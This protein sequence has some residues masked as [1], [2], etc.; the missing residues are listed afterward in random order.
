MPT[1]QSII[2]TARSIYNDSDSVL[3]RKEDPELL[4]YL[5]DGI[6]EISVLKPELF[7]TIGDMETTPGA[8]EHSVTFGDAQAL[9]EVLCIHDGAA[10][11]EFDMRVMD[12]FNPGWRTDTAAAAKQ[13]AR[14][15]GDLLRFF[16]WPPAP[17]S[18]TI[19]VRYIR[20]PTVLGLTD[21]ITEIP[22]TLAPA[23]V[24]YV[25]YRAESADDEHAVSG[26]ATAHFQS[27][28]AKVKG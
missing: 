6:S 13:W 25:V 12:A 10:L 5:N 27:F 11:T 24:D 7:S 19:D 16:I 15:P 1:P 28:V 4:G 26:R 21:P 23:L 9:V 14:K 18:Q 22:A 20:I 3:Y 17:A 8:V 2:T